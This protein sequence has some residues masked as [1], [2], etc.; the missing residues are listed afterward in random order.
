MSESLQWGHMVKN[1]AGQK[2]GATLISATDGSA[3]AG[4]V[5]VYVT[6]DAGAQ[7]AGSVGSGAC[8]NEG[9][10]YYTYAPS[11]AETNG[12][13]VA[14]TFIGTGAVPSTVQ[15]YTSVTA[16]VASI[17]ND[18]ITAAS[19]ANG[20]ID[21][22][23]FAAGAIDAAAIAT[24][25]IDADAIAADAGTEIGTAVWATTARTLTAATNITST[26]GTTVPQTG[27]SFAVVNSGTYGN[28][29]LNTKIGTPAD[30]GNG[31]ATLA[32]NLSDID[33][34][35]DLILAAVSGIGTSGGAA[36]NADAAT[37]NSAGGITGVTVATTKVGT[38]ASGTYASTSFVDGVYHRIDAAANAITWVYQFLTG[39]G[40][41][42]IGV[43]WTG[44]QTVVGSASSVA[45]WNHVGGAWEVIG[46]IAGQP[47]TT[48]IVKNFVLYPRH[49]GTSSAEL[50]KVYLRFLRVSGSSISLF[51]DQVYVTYAITSRTAGYANG[52]IWVKATGA[53]GVEAYVNGTADNP[54]PWADALTL[55]TAL[56]IRQFEIATGTTITLAADLKSASLSGHGWF[57]DTA[58]YD[59][60][61][62]RIEGCEGLTGISTAGD[63]ECFVYNSQI[64]AVTMGEFDM[65]DA[66]IT[67]VITL[68]QAAPYLI[69]HC[70]GVP[71]GGVPTLAFGATADARAV[72]VAGFGGQLLVTG[73]R[74][75]NVLILDG[76]CDLTIDNTNTAGT[77]YISGCVRLTYA[78]T[79]QTV[80]DTARWSEDQSVTGVT[81][82][83]A[84]LTATTFAEPTSVPAATATMKDMLHWL[85]TMSRNKRTQTADTATLRNDADDASIG[86]ASTSDN[87]TTFTSGEWS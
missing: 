17:A 58:G 10:S 11:Q 23:T 74:A 67:G 59:I 54:C 25:A 37:D 50:G 78:G 15:V 6:V 79:G 33:T 24:G 41:T 85:F 75:G 44:Y 87:G 80:Y 81:G 68:A 21:A 40:T 76:D 3:F 43:T 1:T 42:P 38:Q 63:H 55:S 73:M 65:H 20:A 46:T 82:T 53:A 57:L 72:V 26:G 52:S 22:S 27:D 30:L 39:G 12:D 83:V 62:T 14:F 29:A 5:T 49:V 69:N 66:H 19:I 35:T 56:G 60:S 86:T 64:V 13:L 48:N 9:N 36:V 4:S 32:G 61:Y 16:N 47:G 34:E 51:T 28:A 2:I 84:A 77:V 31:T 71:A 7:A 70:V 8:T 18:A 45:A